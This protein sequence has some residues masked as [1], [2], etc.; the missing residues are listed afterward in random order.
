MNRAIRRRILPGSDGDLGRST[1]LISLGL[2]GS[3]GLILFC[4]SMFI[5]CGQSE[6]VAVKHAKELGQA[7]TSRAAVFHDCASQAGLTFRWG[8]GGRSPLNIKD[9]AEG[10]CAFLDYDV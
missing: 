4:A 8:H 1:S 6:R 2:R 7:D 10:G 3:S 9:T 5:G